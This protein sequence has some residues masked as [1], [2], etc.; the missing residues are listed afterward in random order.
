MVHEFGHVLLHRTGNGDT[1][2]DKLYGLVENPV[3][4]INVVFPASLRI[5]NEMIFGRFTHSVAVPT[6]SAPTP[7]PPIPPATA[8]NWQRGH[9]GWGSGADRPAIPKC[10]RNSVPSEVTNIDPLCFPLGLPFY[11]ALERGDVLVGPCAAGLDSGAT[12]GVPTRFQQNPCHVNN[13]MLQYPGW[14]TGGIDEVPLLGDT[15]AKLQL[16]EIEE[17]AGDMFLNWVYYIDGTSEDSGFVNLIWSNKTEST[18]D[19]IP[20]GNARNNWMNCSMTRL[21]NVH[22]FGVSVVEYHEIFDCNF[23]FNAHD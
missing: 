22:Q 9:R 8:S 16:I 17:T 7:L 18:L 12:I 4:D 2:I 6:V 11:E 5:G 19:T 21:F 20:S 10:R 3:P 1:A 13:W 14:Y 15:S 23:G